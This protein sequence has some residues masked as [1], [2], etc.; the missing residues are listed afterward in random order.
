MVEQNCARLRAH[1]NNVQ[2]YHQLLKT[3]LTDFERKFIEQRLLEEESAIE[4]LSVTV[5]LSFKNTGSPDP[6]RA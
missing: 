3:R 4:S 1:H 6:R 5:P 2:R